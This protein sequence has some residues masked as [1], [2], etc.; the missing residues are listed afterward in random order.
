MAD[1]IIVYQHRRCGRMVFPQPRARPTERLAWTCPH[2]GNLE[3]GVVEEVQLP[4]LGS[5][6]ARDS[7]DE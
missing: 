3:D 6:E 2:C 4:V 1:S 7:G 5:D